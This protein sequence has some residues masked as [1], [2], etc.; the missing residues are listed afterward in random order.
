MS[1]VTRHTTVGAE[2]FEIQHFVWHDLFNKLKNITKQTMTYTLVD[3]MSTN[4]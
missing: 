2:S 4:R 3:S 1:I